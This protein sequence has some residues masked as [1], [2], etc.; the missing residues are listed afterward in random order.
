MKPILCAALVFAVL[1]SMFTVYA[2]TTPIQPN[3]GTTITWKNVAPPLGP[4]F[5]SGLRIGLW[6]GGWWRGPY[7]MTQK[8]K[9]WRYDEPGVVHITYTENRNNAGRNTLKIKCGVA[10]P[11]GVVVSVTDADVMFIADGTFSMGDIFNEGDAD[12]APLHAVYLRAFHMDSTEVT[13]AHWDE[14]YAWAVT[15]GYTFDNPGAGKAATHPVQQVNWYD[16]AKWCNARSEMQGLTPC[17]YTD[18]SQGTVYRN[19]NFAVLNGAVKW[20]ANGYRLPTEAEWE[21]AA[22]GG[23]PGQRFPWNDVQWISFDRANYFSFWDAG[24]PFYRYDHAAQAGYNPS[25]VVGATPYTSPAGNFAANGYGMHDMAG[26]VWEWCWD[27][28]GNAYYASAPPSDPPG[29]ASGDFRALRGGGWHNNAYYCRVADRDFGAPAEGDYSSGFRC[30]RVGTPPVQPNYGTLLA[31]KNV[32]PSLGEKFTSEL[33]IGLWDGG[34]WRGPYIMT[35]FGATWRYEQPGVVRITYTE[36][37]DDARRNRLKIRSWDAIPVG[38]VVSV[39]DGNDTYIADGT[40]QMGDPLNESDHNEVPFHSAYLSAFSMD[41]RE[42]TKAQWDA[43]Y[44]WA[45]AHGYTF[46]NPGA[47]KAATHPVQTVNWYDCVKWCNARSQMQGLTPCYYTDATQSTVYKNG[48]VSVANNAVKWDANGY[49]LPTEAEWEK[50]AR[51]G[52]PLNRFPWNDVQTIAR[53]RA[54]YVG[55]TVAYPYDAG[56]N[57]NNPLFM[58]GGEPYTS[59]VGHYAANGYGLYDMAGNVWEWCWD[60]YGDTYYQSAP[61][62]DPR[63]PASG[64]SRM[65]RGGS[66]H[67]RAVNCR[68][69]FR[70]Y[71]DPS[72]AINDTG[73]RCV[74]R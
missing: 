22:R 41:N 66:W 42:V 18:M 71:V 15:H 5:A 53:A 48:M 64:V 38:V 36:K 10:I 35:R 19:G 1:L 21:K 12:E 17:Y 62:N 63:G 14:V 70:G 29:P 26:N 49:R 4:K 65:L 31:W 61:A 73:F 47:G 20:D 55:D 9:A 11:V 2:D 45:L 56:P 51:G 34:W 30:A 43:V 28:Y 46:D 68:S 72:A 57:G 40:F 32:V 39:T 23:V 3:N 13:K 33:R 58:I 59:P 54:N 8:G 27:N 25:F 24:V 52:T 74:R 50:A 60:N 44:T 69:A 6:N 67:G 37:R 16:C 7:A